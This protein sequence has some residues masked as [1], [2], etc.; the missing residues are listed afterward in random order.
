MRIPGL[1]AG[2]QYSFSMIAQN[3]LTLQVSF[4]NFDLG[5]FFFGDL[6][7]LVFLSPFILPLTNFEIQ[8]TEGSSSTQESVQ[9]FTTPN[10]PHPRVRDLLK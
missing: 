1:T 6:T 7:V 9:T 8:S 3:E 4:L 5:V 10:L 2:E